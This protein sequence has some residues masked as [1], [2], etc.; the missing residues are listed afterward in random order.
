MERMFGRVTLYTPLIPV[1]YGVPNKCLAFPLCRKAITVLMLEQKDIDRFNGKFRESTFGCH[2]WSGPLD[3]DGYGSFHLLGKAR[4]AHR[5][6]W[7]LGRGPIPEGMVIEH[8]C[9]NRACV[10]PQHLKLVTPRENTLFN[11]TSVG[12]INAKKTHCKKGHPF[13]RTYNSRR[14]VVRYCSICA[15]EKTKRLR[16]KYKDPMKGM[17]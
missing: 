1:S 8:I 10:N 16:A 9:R 6:G 2:V 13:D 14:G 15:S 3:R 7:F 17:I 4:R 11:S 12:A 5:V